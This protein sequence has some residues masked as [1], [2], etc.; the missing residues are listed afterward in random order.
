[1]D[2]PDARFSRLVKLLPLTSAMARQRFSSCAVV[3]SSP[4]LLMYK[5]GQEIDAHEAVFRA[6]LATIG[7]FE[8]HAGSR[9]TV[10]VINPVESVKKARAKGG[11]DRDETLIVKNQDPPSIRSPSREHGVHILLSLV[12]PLI[13]MLR[14]YMRL[15]CVLCR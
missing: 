8:A 9:T 12:P 11:A 2:R 14:Q 4:E 6:N 10:R 13:R 3:G 1:M 15:G 7:G 5:D